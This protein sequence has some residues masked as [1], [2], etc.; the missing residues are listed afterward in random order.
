[1]DEMSIWGLHTSRT[2]FWSGVYGAGGLKPRTRFAGLLREITKHR[3]SSRKRKG[4]DYLVRAG[5]IYKT[6]FRFYLI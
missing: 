1:M 3:R 5:A 6:I 2:A 4:K